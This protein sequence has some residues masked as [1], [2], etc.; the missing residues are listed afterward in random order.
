MSR[1]GVPEMLAK[2]AREAGIGHVHPHQLRHTWA[3]RWLAAGGSEGDL[4]RLGGWE[5][6]EIM[7]RYGESRAVDRALA[8]YDT[9]DLMGS[10]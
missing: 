4:Q 6:P 9:I 1:K 5:S 3:D 10:L 7:R 2:R 8:A